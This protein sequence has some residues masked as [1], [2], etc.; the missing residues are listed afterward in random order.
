MFILAQQEGPLPYP[1][2][3]LI[4]RDPV[5]DS[6]WAQGPNPPKNEFLSFLDGADDMLQRKRFATTALWVNHLAAAFDALRAA[7]IHNLPLRQNLRIQVKT[8][9]R[10]GSPALR[11]SLEGRF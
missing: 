7:R 8:A 6:G 3:D 10:A 2:P 5:Y 1:T 9:W 4:G 11:A